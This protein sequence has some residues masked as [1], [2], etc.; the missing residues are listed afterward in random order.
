MYKRQY[1]GD[2]V[3]QY[4][5][6]GSYQGTETQSDT[7][8]SAMTTFHIEIYSSTLTS[9]RLSLIKITAGT[10]EIP[11]TLPLVPGQWNVFN[12]DISGASFAS[13]RPNFRQIKYD[14]PAGAGN[15]QNLII[16]NMFFWRPATLQPPTV[17]TFTVAAQPV[18]APNYTLVPPTS[19]N[20]SPFTYSSSNGTVAT[21]VN[22][23][24]LQINGAG[25]SIITASQV[26]DG[27][28]GPS[29]SIATLNVTYPAPGPSPTPPVRDPGTTISMYTGTP[30]VLG[31]PNPV[32]YNMV[33][34]PWTLSLIHI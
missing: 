30:V 22:G 33:R 34:A 11:T 14:Q 12:I 10:V 15:I 5:N 8:V 9:I 29:S 6:T 19:N 27:T 2:A 13:V 26:S 4:Q 17:G 18:G 32:G 31:Y 3:K 20:T 16:D 24:E 23:N 25:S 7:N 21:V 28:Y 1:G